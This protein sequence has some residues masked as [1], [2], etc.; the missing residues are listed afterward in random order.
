MGEIIKVTTSNVMALSGA[1]SALRSN[2]PTLIDSLSRYPLIC[3][4]VNYGFVF[5]TSAD[6]DSLIG[7]LDTKIDALFYA[8]C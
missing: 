4:F 2:R 5:E 3:E 6:I 1:L 7:N 8:H